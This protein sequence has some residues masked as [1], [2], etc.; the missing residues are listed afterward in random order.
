MFRPIS[1][2][3]HWQLTPHPV[4]SIRDRHPCL[5]C[6]YMHVGYVLASI[7]LVVFPLSYHFFLSRSIRFALSQRLLLWR[8][9]PRLTIQ[10]RVISKRWREYH[11]CF[12][13]KTLAFLIAPS[14]Y[15]LCL[16]D[17]IE[18]KVN[19]RVSTKD[20]IYW[21]SHDTFAKDLWF[22]RASCLYHLVFYTR[23]EEFKDLQF[24][25][26][27]FPSLWIR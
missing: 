18:A 1:Q 13:A 6:F 24:Y 14:S 15:Y 11:I 21:I 2:P 3:P 19:R 4:F 16:L 26:F 23:E 8:F 7:S 10:S 5:N 22:W 25:P 9:L 17:R 20:Q 12:W 27:L